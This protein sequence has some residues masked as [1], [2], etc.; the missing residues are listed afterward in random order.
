MKKLLLIALF[1]IGTAQVN[2]QSATTNQKG[3]D[4]VGASTVN[5]KSESQDILVV[6]NNLDALK[7]KV[8]DAPILLESFDIHFANGEKK[9][10]EYGGFNAIPLNGREVT[11]VTIR[12][13]NIDATDRKAR[14]ELMGLK[15]SPDRD[16]SN[17][18]SR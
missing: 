18:A 1:A 8:K 14:I 5:F 11:K 3:W 13:K 15:T 16:N 4:N 7:I 6:G 10:V 2:G 17:L 12:Y 9:T